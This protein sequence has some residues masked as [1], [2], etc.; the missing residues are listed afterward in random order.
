MNSWK[1]SSGPRRYRRAANEDTVMRP[2]LKPD[3]DVSPD[4]ISY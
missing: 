4:C 3:L 2:A 1:V